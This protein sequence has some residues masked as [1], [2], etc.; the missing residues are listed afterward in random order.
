MS[1]IDHP[2]VGG[3]EAP[4]ARGGGFFMRLFVRIR[5]RPHDRSRLSPAHQ[6]ASQREKGR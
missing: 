4:R 2:A 3:G 6:Q 1:L 5:A